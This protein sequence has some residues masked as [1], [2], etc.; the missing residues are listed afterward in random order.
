M[1]GRYIMWVHL[2]NPS[3]QW[4]E[5]Y[6]CCDSLAVLLIPPILHDLLPLQL[7]LPDLPQSLTRPWH[8][9]H[10]GDPDWW[11][12]CLYRVHLQCDRDWAR[13]KR[14]LRLKSMMKPSHPVFLKLMRRI[15]TRR[16]RL[17]KQRVWV[18]YQ[19]VRMNHHH[20][21]KKM[22]TSLIMMMGSILTR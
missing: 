13:T 3:R 16:R 20:Q 6:H 15:R 22:I 9:P 2:A 5:P 12:G 7:H 18:S 17:R 8:L 1:W 19:M 21:H 4:R 14:I 11:P 10:L